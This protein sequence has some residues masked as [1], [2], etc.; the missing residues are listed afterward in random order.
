MVN[1]FSSRYG[2]KQLARWYGRKLGQ[3]WEQQREAEEPCQEKTSWNEN[4]NVSVGCMCI[5]SN[6]DRR[7]NATTET[8]YQRR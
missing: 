1:T 5:Q 8:S 4:E 3:I 6:K 7:K 2:S